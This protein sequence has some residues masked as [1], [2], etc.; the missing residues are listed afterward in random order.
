MTKSRLVKSDDGFTGQIFS[1]IRNNN[2]NVNGGTKSMELGGLGL[3]KNADLRV[4][5]NNFANIGVC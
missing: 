2:I 1:R 5:E 3:S 4:S